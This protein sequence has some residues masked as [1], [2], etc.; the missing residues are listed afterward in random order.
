MLKI[1]ELG[2]LICLL[3]LGGNPE[4][5]HSHKLQFVS[6][7]SFKFEESI[8]YP[9]GEEESFRHESIL[10][11]HFL[12]PAEEHSSHM[13][14]EVGLIREVVVGHC[15]CFAERENVGIDIRPVVF[16]FWEGRGRVFK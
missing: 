9:G 1:G 8:D 14:G 16:C 5:C 15:R 4:G 7:D 12:K 2:D 11:V 6:G 3:E 13:L 10:L